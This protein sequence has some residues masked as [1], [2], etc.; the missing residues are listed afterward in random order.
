MFRLIR[1]TI[2]T[3]WERQLKKVFPS[4]RNEWRVFLVCFLGAVFWWF[5]HELSKTHTVNLSYPIRFKYDSAYI[6]IN[7]LPENIYFQLN[8]SGWQILPL[9]IGLG[10]DELEYTFDDFFKPSNAIN[11]EYKSDIDKVSG[12]ITVNISQASLRRKLARLSQGLDPNSMDELELV[13]DL[14][15]S[16]KLKVSIKNAIPLAKNFKISGKINIQPAYINLKGSKYALSKLPDNYEIIFPNEKI[17]EDFSTSFPIKLPPNLA[18]QMQKSHEEI[19]ISFQV[20]E[21]EQ[22]RGEIPIRKVGFPDNIQLA[23]PNISFLYTVPKNQDKSDKELLNDFIIVANFNKYDSS[24]S[25]VALEILKIPKSVYIEDIQLAQS[26]VKI[27]YENT[28]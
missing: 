11:K 18:R 22:K 4:T 6:P 27:R 20:K 7:P 10:L 14:L 17:N 5:F 8:T 28:P 15:E 9:Y 1:N 26:K 19:N 13:F 24:D 3:I 12:Q 2:L 16:K 25:S 23:K 21:F